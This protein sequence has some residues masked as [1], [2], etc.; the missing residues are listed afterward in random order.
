M[1]IS[2]NASVGVLGSTY[3]I[4]IGQNDGSSNNSLLVTGSST[5]T[6][7][8]GLDVGLYGSGNSLLISNEG[9]VSGGYGVIGFYAN[10]SN[11]SV[12][13]TGSNSKLLFT[14]DD[15]SGNSLYIGYQGVSNSLTITNGG[16]LVV[17]N[18]IDMSSGNSLTIAGS[19]STATVYG[20][21]FVGY[22]GVGNSLSVTGGGTLTTLGG[23]YLGVIG[24]SNSG[25]VTGIGSVWFNSNGLTLGNNSGQGDNLTVS[26]GG[27]IIN[28]GDLKISYSDTSISNNWVLVTDS[29]SLL[30]N[31]GTVYVGLSGSGT[32]T[33]ANGGAVVADSGISITTDNGSVS[34]LNIGSLG[35]SDTAGTITTPTI[36][37][38]SGTGTINFNQINTANLTS[39]ISG[40][41]TVNQLGSGTTILSG[42]N[43]GF[44]GL[45]T[46]TNGSLQFGDGMTPGG[47]P[48]SGNISN[49]A[50]LIFAP[51]ISDTYTVN[52]NISG[53]GTIT[54]NGFGTTVLAGNNNGFTNGTAVVNSGTLSLPTGLTVSSFIWNG[55]VIALP[56][57]AAGNYLATGSLTLTTTGTFDLAGLSGTS[58]VILSADNLSSFSTSD[59]ILSGVSPTD[60]SLQISGNQLWATY[61][62]PPPPPPPPPPDL[63]VTNGIEMDITSGS[64]NY[65]T[66]YIGYGAGDSNNALVVSGSGIL[67]N[68]ADLFVGYSNSTSNTMTVVGGGQVFVSGSNYGSVIGYYSSNNAVLVSDAG[69]LWSNAM[70]LIVGL[71]GSGTLTVANSGSVIADGGI[72]LAS[73]AGSIG[74][75]NIGSYGGSD[76]AGTVGASMITFGSGS[77]TINFNQSDTFTL[78]SSISGTGSVNQLGSGTTILTAQNSYGGLT[79]VSGGTL[80]AASTNALGSSAVTLSGGTIALQTNLTINSL[81]WNTGASVAIS[82][83]GTYLTAT[84]SVTMNT[85]GNFDLTGMMLGANTF[86]LFDFGANGLT[87]NQFSISGLI[88]DYALSISNTALYIT[89]ILPPDL[90]VGS[91]SS[92]V[93]SNFTSGTNYYGNAYVGY[94]SD[95][96]ASNNALLV[97]ETNTLLIVAGALYVGNGGSSNSL[98]ISSGAV[99]LVLGADTSTS[100]DSRASTTIGSLPGDSFNS[101]VVSGGSTFSNASGFV[102]GNLDDAN[103]NS[104]TV[105]GASTLT[106]NN[107]RIGWG[108]FSGS[109]SNTLT[110]TD[111]NTLY[112]NAGFLHVGEA[113]GKNMLIVSNGAVAL[114]MGADNNN[115]GTTIGYDN[116]DAGN[117]IVVTGQGS[118][119][120]NGFDLYVGYGGSGNSLIV[121]NGG[122]VSVNTTNG[123]MGMV[124]GHDIGASGNSFF[125]TGSNSTL[126]SGF[127]MVVGWDG[128]SNSMTISGGAHVTNLFYA[129]SNGVVIGMTTNASNNSVLVTGSGSTWNINNPGFFNN[130]ANELTVG[131]NGSFNSLTISNG[132]TVNVGSSSNI[133]PFPNSIAVGFYSNAIGNQILVTGAGS[134]LNATGFMVIGDSFGRDG[135]NLSNSL[136]VA[137]GGSVH[138]DYLVISPSATLMDFISLNQVAISGPGSTLVAS[139]GIQITG[140]LLSV[141]NGGSLTAGSTVGSFFPG[142]ITIDTG[143]IIVGTLDGSGTG[144]TIHAQTI[145]LTNSGPFGGKLGFLQKDVFNLSSSISDDGSGVLYQAGSG[146]TI[147]SGD[148]GGF[149]GATLITNGTLIAASTNALGSS[150][151]N[152]GSGGTLSL[153]TNLT[154]NLLN[155]D[156]S[157]SIALPGQ[158]SNNYANSYLA[159]TNAAILTGSGT[160]TFDLTGARPGVT[161]MELFDFGM[162][163]FTVSQFLATGLLGTLFTSNDILYFDPTGGSNNDLYVG[164]NSSSVIAVFS[165]GSNAYNE[166][167]VGYQA[168]DANNQLI[169]SNSGTL[170]AS[171]ADLY[172]GYDGATNRATISGGG[173][174]ETYRTYIGYGPDSSNNSMVIDGNSLWNNGGDLAVGYLGSSNTLTIS[175]ASTLAVKGDFYGLNATVIGYDANSE[176]NSVLL[177]GNSIWSNA[178]D[179]YVGYGGSVN[180][181]VISNGS[182]VYVGGSSNGTVIGYEHTAIFNGVLVTGANSLLSNSLGVIVGFSGSGEL[183]IAN[184][185]QVIADGGI[186]IAA[187]SGSS[188]YLFIGTPENNEIAGSLVTPMITFGLGSSVLGFEQKDTITLTSSII[189]PGNIWQEGFG[190]T[191]ISGNSAGFTGTNHVNAGILEFANTSALYGGNTNLWTASNIVVNGG[192]VAFAVGGADAFTA[193]NITLL[194]GNLTNVSSGGLY[195]AGGFG[196]DSTGTNFTLTN[197]IGDS[198]NGQLAM[199]FIGSG[200]TTVTGSNTYTGNTLV[201]GG[202]LIVNGSIIGNNQ[203]YVG[204]NYAGSA[205]TISSNSQVFS[206]DSWV[207]FAS[208]Y[209]SNSMASANSNSM[210][211]IGSGVLFS[212]ATNCELGAAY[213]SGISNNTISLSNTLTISNFGQ[214]TISAFIPYALMV[215]DAEAFNG[216]SL[217]SDVTSV[218]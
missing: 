179:L 137:N 115:A 175:G 36:T 35:G 117:S 105:S 33:I 126:F 53:S 196:I 167:Y 161:P 190:M 106:G 55:G 2:S 215:G 95:G 73:D 70:G 159:V 182:A 177:T 145:T 7:G 74:T 15:G 127:D 108:F 13:V 138:V 18:S 23:S 197:S 204:E 93:S 195:N 3:G 111:S 22:G 37:F 188:G 29:G 14:G 62:A 1:T 98:T 26:A 60:Y 181:L 63:Y 183:L 31:S 139:N 48:V 155:W 171:M 206:L 116:G 189:G 77:G 76:S 180:S 40:A 128:S 150:V 164:S 72:V 25:I 99:T 113:G 165:S 123:N 125:I 6:S 85:I 57:A 153:Q 51:S 12:T 194:L 89:G 101:V 45:T 162:N 191:I 134:S 58:A 96:S 129:A 46:I 131:L 124:V 122:S 174:L 170:L 107:D 67:S 10:A 78:T 186:T 176:F 86:E 84:G 103:N 149:S 59:F 210:L 202:A 169:V 207:G 112:T 109:F 44:S 38:G 27:Q 24:G 39:S 199:A 5:L 168:G 81:I 144:G 200:T 8:R 52:G 94:S 79:I 87:T 54:H 97:S 178:P 114:V 211:I 184:R 42:N 152:L 11:N 166:I 41:G 88:G 34:T 198:V 146:T 151:V 91:N 120:T 16:S 49:N 32:L 136:T 121:S 90:Y 64:S 214:L 50:T 142:G 119:L 135:F 80:V 61:T 148:N 217:V 21:L 140:G 209:G 208:S 130:S 157:S 100:V 82:A 158:I 187:N 133:G 147:I 205:M 203:I 193:D 185:A 68:Y 102:I 172:V 141:A 69:S 66:T 201:N 160:N 4:V 56:G 132:A 20:S 83:P 104:M 65:S 213:A 47:A 154:I 156:S 75:L 118:T 92:G 218:I 212:N 9:A 17:S 43:S 19:N 192:V 110:I 173:T 30:S 163:A 216:T 28:N 71:G 143:G